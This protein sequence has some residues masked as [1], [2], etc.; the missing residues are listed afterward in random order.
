[1]ALFVAKIWIPLSKKIKENGKFALGG[2]FP[3]YIFIHLREGTP[4]KENTFFLGDFSQMW[5]GGRGERERLFGSR[6]REVKLKI[7]FPFYRKG[8]GIR[9]C[10]GK[11]R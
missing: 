4:P 10:F 5:V 2:D 8:T 11:G 7:T 9:K 1:M 6:E 3:F